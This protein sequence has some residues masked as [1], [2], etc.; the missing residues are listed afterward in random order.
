[1][2]D[3]QHFAGKRVL[4]TGGMGFIGSN[5]ALRLVEL[6]ADVTVVDAMIPGYGANLFNINP[7]RDKVTVNFAD[8][9][10]QQVMNYLVRDKDYVFHLAG[11]VD[12]VLSLSDPFPD[13]DINITGTAVVMEALRNHNPDAKVIYTG[14][15]G[16][17]GAT[18]ELPVNEDAPTYPKGLHEISSL[19][20]EKI[21]Y[22]YHDIHKIPAVLLRLTNIFGERAQM[23]HPRYGVV[24]WFVRLAVDD[25]EIKVFGDGQI[26]RDFLYIDDCI[27]A[28]LHTAITDE[29]YGEIINVASGKPVNFVEL[30]DTLI[31]AAQS[32]RWSFAPF[33]PERA[34]QEPGHFYA[35]ISKIQRLTNWHPS[36][37]LADGLSKTVAYYRQ[38][39]EHYWE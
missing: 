16:Q 30:A 10:D 37:S 6:G 5:L 35:D 21:I 25:A 9:R 3:A 38:H 1:M 29:A 26:L 28:M 14:T 34:A 18:V 24:N 4:I 36:T 20:A 32:G 12:H 31:D 19:T 27:D 15:R 22:M 23:K 13:I 7:I 11:Q 2:I 39:K 33:S 8:I 17:Y